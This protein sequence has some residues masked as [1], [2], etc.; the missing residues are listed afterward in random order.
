MRVGGGLKQDKSSIKRTDRRQ[1]EKA[2]DERKK[3]DCEGKK[4]FY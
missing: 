1:R 2:A 4:M 3:Q